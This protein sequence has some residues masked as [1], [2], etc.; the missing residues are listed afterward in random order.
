MEMRAL[1]KSGLRV[2]ALGFGGGPL[3]YLD[4]DQAQATRVLNSLLDGGVTLIDTAAAYRGSEEL[5]GEA[6][7]HRRDECVLVS[8]CG[9]DTDGTDWS[10]SGIKRGVERAL[11]RLKT[12]HLD[13]MLLHTC[14]LETLKQ[15]EALNALVAARDAGKC[16]FIGYSGDNE[17]VAF[18]VEHEAVDVVE[19]S[20]NI[21]DQA[22][23][24][25]VFPNIRRRNIGVLAKRPI[26][27]AAWTDPAVRRGIYVNYAMNY[28]DRLATMGIQPT[29]LG[30]AEPAELAWPEI[31]LRFTLAHSE[32]STA[33]V[34][35]TDPANVQRNLE[36]AAKGPLPEDVVHQLR[37]AFQLAEAEA[38]EDWPSLN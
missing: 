29:D 35:T 37:N 26:A 33:I 8:K 18:A 16:R 11:Q 7:S 20:V 13:V 34:G 28:S 10:A 1:G 5:I 22:N 4:T 31:A 17:A 6:I 38:G 23:I 3:G 2:S 27:N 12:D 32:V 30:F 19:M 15:G 24:V 14:D 25:N 36:I 21:C 9:K